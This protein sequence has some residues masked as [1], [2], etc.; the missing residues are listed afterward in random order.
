MKYY[1]KQNY[2]ASNSSIKNHT[3]PFINEALQCDLLQEP[4]SCVNPRLH[5]CVK[6]KL[7]SP[8]SED[9]YKSYLKGKGNARKYNKFTSMDCSNAKLCSSESRSSYDRDVCQYFGHRLQ[10]NGSIRNPYSGEHLSSIRTDS[11]EEKNKRWDWINKYSSKIIMSKATECY[12]EN[13]RA[14]RVFF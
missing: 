5:Q 3:F 11:L 14:P 10:L 4:S 12:L 8:Y 9:N 6:L 2:D 1:S 13:R 7:E